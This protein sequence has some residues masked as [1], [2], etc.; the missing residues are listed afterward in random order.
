VTVTSHKPGAGDN[1]NTTSSRNA[2]CPRATTAPAD[3]RGGPLIL[4]TLSRYTLAP[5]HTNDEKADGRARVRDGGV[6]D[7]G[8]DRSGVDL[9]HP[10]IPG[11]VGATRA[12]AMTGALTLDPGDLGRGESQ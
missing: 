5:L 4:N 6:A 2:E 11:Q 3:G 1:G 7:P 8:T 12:V 9:G 10:V